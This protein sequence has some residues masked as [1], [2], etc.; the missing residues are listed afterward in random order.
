MSL[1]EKIRRLKDKLREST[2]EA[3]DMEELSSLLG[4][5]ESDASEE[6]EVVEV[7]EQ[8][9][10]RE[11]EKAVSPPPLPPVAVSAK[12]SPEYVEIE[13][14]GMQPVVDIQANIKSLHEQLGVLCANFED[15]KLKLRRAIAEGREKLSEHVM[16]LRN[17]NNLSEDVDY[18]LN[19][20]QIRGEKGSFMKKETN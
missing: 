2:L 6:H 14:E 8:D 10:I 19:V 11:D 4:E 3:S 1:A 12:D 7:V 13:W 20:P 15:N 16:S 5:V 18:V 9:I 17:Q